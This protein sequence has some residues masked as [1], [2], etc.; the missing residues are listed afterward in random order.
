MS[1]GAW[2]S[3]SSAQPIA[4]ESDV[5]DGNFAETF[6][7]GLTYSPLN[8]R[9]SEVQEISHFAPYFIEKFNIQYQKGIRSASGPALEAMLRYSWPGN[10]R[11][12]QNCIMRAVIL[13]QGNQLEVED[14]ALDPSAESS[15]AVGQPGV[16]TV[17]PAFSQRDPFESTLE[18]LLDAYEAGSLPLT[19]PC[20]HWLE[21][22]L[23]AAAFEISNQV[24]RQAATRLGIPPTTIRRKLKA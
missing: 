21:D 1:K 12:L 11:E 7:I 3:A 5:E 15:S 24:G 10:I 18:L 9:G 16:R 4:F 8:F 20:G 13:A 22:A 2:T 17:N 19:P 23:V 6:S 14:L